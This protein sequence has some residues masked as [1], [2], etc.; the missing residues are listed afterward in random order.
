MGTLT[1]S[2]VPDEMQHRAAFHQVLHCLLRFKFA[3]IQTIFRDK[4]T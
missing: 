3:Q 1:S 4:N 2:E